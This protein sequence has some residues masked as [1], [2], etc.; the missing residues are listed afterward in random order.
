MSRIE[1]D[2]AYFLH[3]TPYRDN[4]AL[5]HLLTHQHGKISFIVS[6]LKA[7]K[8]AKRPFLQPCRQLTISYQ[9]KSGLSKLEQ[10]DFAQVTQATQV[11]QAPSIAQFMFYQYANELLLTILPPQLPT[12]ILFD[13]YQRFLRLLAD[14][15]PHTALR[16]IELSLINAFGGLPSVTHTED[17]QQPPEAD[18]FYWFSPEHGLFASAP[19]TAGSENGI[20]LDGAQIQAFHHVAN[21]YLH[22]QDTMSETL[23]QGAKALTTC[24]I[25]QLLNGKKLKTRSVYQALQQYS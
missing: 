11:H 24:L 23:A 10:I 20:T 16:Y 3:Q 1:Q 17:T 18:K 15:R 9:L 12:P 2:C 25:Q 14:N 22:I 4:S 6:G 13:N 5:V 21:N 8:N 19:L 7:K